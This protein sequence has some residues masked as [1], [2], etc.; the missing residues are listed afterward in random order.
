[1]TFLDAVFLGIGFAIGYNVVS[2]T[3]VV[4]LAL[5]ALFLENRRLDD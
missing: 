3:V 4:I 5:T 1:M 2:L